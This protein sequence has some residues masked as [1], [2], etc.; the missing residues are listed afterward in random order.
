MYWFQL[1]PTSTFDYIMFSI[2]FG[3]FS[4]INIING[5]EL[6]HKKEWYNKLIGTWPYT[7]FMYSHFLDEHIKG[8]HRAVS[9][10]EDPA[11]A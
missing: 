7:K 2:V 6:L 1:K 9:T 4:A 8:H 5:H 3:Y 10:P 11:T